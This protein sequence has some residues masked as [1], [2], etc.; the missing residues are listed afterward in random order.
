[1]QVCLPTFVLTIPCTRELL[2][3]LWGNML[4]DC[5]KCDRILALP[6]FHTPIIL[7]RLKKGDVFGINP[8]T[9][10][11]GSEKSPKLF[12]NTAAMFVI[13]TG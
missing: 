9:S 2:V 8:Y 4:G 6:P 3:P 7:V 12:D 10:S 5:V 1:M 11:K 13:Y